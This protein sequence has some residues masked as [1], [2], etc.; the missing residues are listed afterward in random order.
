MA[1]DRVKRP[2]DAIFFDIDDTL[3]STSAFARRVR[4]L[5]IRAMRSAGLCG[6]QDF[7]L[8]ELDE[9]VGEFSSNY[10]EHFQRLLLRL[11]AHHYA[12]VNQA[13]LIGAAVAA[14]HDAKV[15]ELA[16]FPDVPAVMRRLARTGLLLGI[17]TDGRAVKQAEKLV[18]LRI[19]RYINPRAIFISEQVGISK[20]NPKLFTRACRALRLD[21]ARTM[22]VGDHPQRDIDPAA[23]LGM[24]TVQCRRGGRHADAVGTAV[25]DHVVRDFRELLSLVRTRYDIRS[26]RGGASS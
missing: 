22:Y 26:R 10:G 8:R 19:L 16:P 14:Y 13:V 9:V 20:P 1:A 15:R 23:A 3:F 24:V 6:R 25:P 12:G 4:V 18:R 11:P 5:C 21:P 17:I 7:L 2:L